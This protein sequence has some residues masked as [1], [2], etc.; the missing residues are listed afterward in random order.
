MSAV[1]NRAQLLEVLQGNSAAI[2]VFGVLRLGVFG[3]FARD[4]ATPQSDVDLFVEF[5]PEGKTLKN[6]LGLSRYL[7]T[8]LG[9]K[10]ELVTPGSLNRFIGKYILEEVQYVPLAA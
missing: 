1:E 10:V 7:E 6:L 9:R 4:T 5:I 2:Q 3:S 8:L